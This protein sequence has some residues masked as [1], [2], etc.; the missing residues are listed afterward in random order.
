LKHCQESKKPRGKSISSQDQEFQQEMLRKL[1]LHLASQDDE[2]EEHSEG[3]VLES[4]SS[5]R[6][7]DHVKDCIST[8]DVFPPT[9]SSF[10]DEQCEHYFI[11]DEECGQA[12]EKSVQCWQ[13]CS[14]CVWVPK[15]VAYG[16][17]RGIAPRQNNPGGKGS[18]G[19]KR[20]FAPHTQEFHEDMLQKLALHLAAQ[21]APSHE[22]SKLR[23]SEDPAPQ[24]KSKTSWADMVDE[25]AEVLPA[26]RMVEEAARPCPSYKYGMNGKDVKEKRLKPN[27]AEEP[28]FQQEMLRKLALHLAAQPESDEGPNEATLETV[29]EARYVGEN[30]A[31]CEQLVAE[32]ELPSISG[33]A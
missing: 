3:A 1:A 22:A 27:R 30:K 8:P 12:E 5:P 29:S 4:L 14:Q 31:H 20:A 9:P 23:Q 16:L 18:K 7:A 10:G 19:G 33:W 32:L 11:G 21:P 28:E 17:L 13:H 26:P 25:D 15:H 6:L 24:S 2:S